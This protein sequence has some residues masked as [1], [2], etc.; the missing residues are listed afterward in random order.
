[1][2]AI[3][4]LGITA[5]EGRFYNEQPCVVVLAGLHGEEPA[6]T[7]AVLS[8]LPEIERT[9]TFPYLVVPNANPAGIA[10]GQPRSPF[11][12]GSV[13][14]NAAF[15]E[16][17]T[18]GRTIGLFLDLHEDDRAPSVYLFGHE[19]TGYAISIRNMLYASGVTFAKDLRAWWETDMPKLEIEE[20][21]VWDFQDGS[22]DDEMS[23]VAPSVVVETPSSMP[24]EYRVAIH[25]RVL[26]HV[27]VLMA[28]IY[29]SRR[30]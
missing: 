20:G 22:V 21:I 24:L 23:L 2:N 14:A 29:A 27:P 13:A 4:V 25:C 15:R 26:A 11:A 3:S 28:E 8:M 7:V 10:K 6:P 9:W 17:L 16:E 30:A 1:M 5:L 12:S 19:G 18:N